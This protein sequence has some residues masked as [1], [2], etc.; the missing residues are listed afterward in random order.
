MADVIQKIKVGNAYQGS[1]VK[2]ILPTGPVG[3][4]TYDRS[5]AYQWSDS[6]ITAIENRLN[7]RFD[8]TTY[9]TA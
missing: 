2:N 4:G 6:V 7:N 1:V 9:Y 8:D 5:R 3:S